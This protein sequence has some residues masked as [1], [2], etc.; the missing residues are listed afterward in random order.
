MKTFQYGFMLVLLAAVL[1]ACSAETA[2]EA[3]PTPEANAAPPEANAPATGAAPTPARPAAP[4]DRAAAPSAPAA[5]RL[6]AV[7][8]GTSFDIVLIDAI[9][10][11]RNQ[12]G[13]LF[14]ASL[15]EPIIVNGT[16]VVAQGTKVQGRIVDAERSGRVSGRANIRLV[17]TG[18]MDGEKSYPI[19]TTPFVAQAEG[20]QGRDAGIIG[21]AAGIGAAIGAI[22]GGGSGAAKGAAIGGAAGTGTVLATRGREVEFSSESKLRFTLDQE[23]QLPRIT[24]RIS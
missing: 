21:G 1:G 15:G 19:V 14:T 23:A 18:I 17:L 3:T 8:A 24:G 4:A 2:E 9:S 12:A 16:T 10:T 22:A 11:E 13:D 5:P 20:T 7:P 6:I